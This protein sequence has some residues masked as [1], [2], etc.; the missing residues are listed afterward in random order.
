MIDEE[1]PRLTALFFSSIRQHPHC[2]C[3]R[4]NDHVLDLQPSRCT[5][6]APANRAAARTVA[7]N[8]ASSGS[9][10]VKRDETV[11]TSLLA[12]V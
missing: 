2:V 7:P 8:P 10:A 5:R 1:G 3:P 6:A 11:L 4:E 12:E 9:R